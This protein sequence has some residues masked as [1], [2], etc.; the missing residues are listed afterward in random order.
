MLVYLT[1]HFDEFQ[2]SAMIIMNI[3][4]GLYF[5][6]EQSLFAQF[7]QFEFALMDVITLFQIVIFS[8]R[9]SVRLPH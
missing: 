5:M 6:V 2:L 7:Q 3:S 4:Y 1:Y 8:E 9:Y